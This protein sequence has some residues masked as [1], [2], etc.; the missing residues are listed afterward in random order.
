MRKI[1][2]D[3]CKYVPIR[4]QYLKYLNLRTRKTQDI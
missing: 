3:Y 2:L 4:K 1:L